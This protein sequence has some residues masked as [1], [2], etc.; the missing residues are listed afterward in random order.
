M[1]AHE[2]PE[3]QKRFRQL[4]SALENRDRRPQKRDAD[5]ILLGAV[6]ENA[7]RDAC[8]KKVTAGVNTPPATGKKA[9]E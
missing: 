4:L 2:R 6:L 8:A 7:L 9:A 3:Q 5:M 1:T